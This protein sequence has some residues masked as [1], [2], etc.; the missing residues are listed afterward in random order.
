MKWIFESIFGEKQMAN[1]TL[2]FFRTLLCVEL[3]LVHGLKKIANVDEEL[4]LLPNPFGIAPH[5]NLYIAI[6][7][8]LVMPLFVITGTF[9]K[10]AIL[11]ILG[12]TLTGYFIVHSNDSLAIRDIPFMYSLSFLVVLLLG[13][14]KYSVDEM[15]LKK[16]I[17][18][19]RI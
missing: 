10:L 2:L 3:M 16:L 1:I 11:P 6:I 14:G 9:T 19:K 18:K 17:N 5:L 13:P 8:N 7:A 12:I 4:K 15:I